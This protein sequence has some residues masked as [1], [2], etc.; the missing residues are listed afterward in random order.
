MKKAVAVLIVMLFL[1]SSREAGPQSPVHLVLPN[2]NLLRCY[3]QANCSQLWSETVK[4]KE[5]FPKQMIVDVDHGCIYAMTAV[6]DKSVPFDQIA[7]VINDRYQQWSVKGTTSPILRLWRVEP[8][9]FAIQLSV[10][11]K[12]DERRRIAATGTKLAIYITF[13]GKSACSRS[14]QNH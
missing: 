9:R 11:D 2:P 3:H 4:E 7:S 1:L 5:I 12:R 13:G 6:Y 10:A 14:P 8:Q